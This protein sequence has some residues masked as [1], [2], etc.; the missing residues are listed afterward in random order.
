MGQLGI[1]T[2]G[3]VQKITILVLIKLIMPV[4]LIAS[5]LTY[6]LKHGVHVDIL[7]GQIIFGVGFGVTIVH[8]SFS[9]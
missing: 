7:I 8:R 2:G 5:A 1:L 3:I 6:L 4:T 9:T